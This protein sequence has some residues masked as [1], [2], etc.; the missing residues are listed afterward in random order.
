MSYRFWKPYVPVAVRRAQAKKT[1]KE[2][3]PVVVEGRAIARTFWG[4]AWC[5]NLE[6]YSDYENRLPRGR[7]YVRN[8]SVV[9][10]AI[11][12]GKVRALVMGSHLYTIDIAILPLP[13]KRWASLAKECTGSI[14]SLV[15][16]LQGKFSKAV[17][18][19]IC[20]PRTG[21]FPSPKE[22]RLD[23]SCPDWASMC[24]H[25][26]ATLYGIGA[27][28]DDRPELL[29]TL[30]QV[31][32]NDLVTQAAEFSGKT[33]KGS[34]QSHVLADDRLEDVFGLD[35]V[36]VERPV[37]PVKPG[38]RHSKSGKVPGEKTSAPAKNNLSRNTGKKGVPL[39][40]NSLKIPVKKGPS[41]PAGR[42]AATSPD[43]A[44]NMSAKKGTSPA[45]EKK[46]GMTPVG[47]K[48]PSL[49]KRSSSVQGKKAPARKYRKS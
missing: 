23:C 38:A 48:K 29:F 8:G 11:K 42:K 18:E 47:E 24:K 45:S 46:N 34:G 39:T 33:S 3:S 2:M 19:R 15:E 5:D 6:A 16:L 27:R 13:G 12:R 36:S 32:A 25:V 28:L 26:A 44:S 1:G 43:V 4:K 22:I 21:L 20:Q 41:S 9:D 14:A 7:S 40:G 10:L 17:M 35:M 31:D 30:R 49:K 37:S